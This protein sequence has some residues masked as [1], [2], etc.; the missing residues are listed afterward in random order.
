MDV[1][2]VE[3]V[4]VTN[5]AAFKLMFVNYKLLFYQPAKV[6]LLS[7]IIIFQYADI[8]SFNDKN[9]SLLYCVRLVCKSC[10]LAG[11]PNNIIPDAVVRI[12]LKNLAMTC[13][14]SIFSMYP[15]SFLLYLLLLEKNNSSESISGDD[16]SHRDDGNNN[17]QPIS[18]IML[19]ADH[20][21]PQ[22]RGAVRHAVA[23]YLKSALAESNGCYEEWCLNN[24]LAEGRTSRSDIYALKNIITFIKEASTLTY[25]TYL[26]MYLQKLHYNEVYVHT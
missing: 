3:Q 25:L 22:L 20:S 4:R 8:G 7:F 1:F 12:T 9:V 10:I 26:Y 21:D 15:S 2:D 17:R 16:G 6:T 24:T 11:R 14:S 19:L 5:Y 13:L 23:S 18:D